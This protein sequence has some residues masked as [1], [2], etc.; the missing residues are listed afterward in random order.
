LVQRADELLNAVDL[1]NCLLEVDKS[2][3]V[4]ADAVFG[5]LGG[6]DNAA[7]V[8]GE[9]VV[10][11][12]NSRLYG[13]VEM[14][15]KVDPE[16]A[17]YRGPTSDSNI[18]HAACSHSLPS[19]LCID[20][21]TMASAFYKDGVQHINS[22]GRLPVHSAA[23]FSDVEVLEF[24]LGL[25]PEGASVVTIFGQNLLHLA[26]YDDACRAA[27]KMQ[28]LCSRYPAMIQQTDNDGEMPVHVEIVAASDGF[29]TALALY[30]AGGIEQ[31][32]TP[33]AHPTSANYEY[34]GYLPLH[35]FILHESD[36]LKVL[37]Q[38][39]SET[40]DMFRWLLHLYPEAAGIEDG[41]GAADRK[42]PYQL[43]VD[44]NLPK[45]YRRLLLRAA[46]TLNPAELHRLNYEQRRMAM[47]LAF[48]AITATTEVPLLVRL[49][50]EGKDLIQRVVSFL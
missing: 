48:R 50:G 1:V 20:I 49:R 32:K 16:A 41:V 3:E 26:V 7:K 38:G 18:L 35:L 45:Y 13:M 23:R 33:V 30:E 12:R 6:Y 36:S 19:K 14:Q 27:P 11:R 22:L 10:D 9:A 46:P 47:L 17:K 40:A 44:N 8:G 43:A 34:N 2:R 31:F 42:T 4:V 29:K 28:Y 37:S 21:L 15:L 39:T 25:Y 5:C 24:L